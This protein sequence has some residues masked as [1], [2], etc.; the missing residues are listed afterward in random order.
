MAEFI[1]MAGH[2]AKWQHTI[3]ATCAVFLLE[4]CIQA[5]SLLVVIPSYVK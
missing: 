4:I 5:Y 3:F 1:N 2:T